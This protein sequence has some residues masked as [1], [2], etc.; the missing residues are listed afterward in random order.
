MDTQVLKEGVHTGF[1][2]I[3]CEEGQ[4]H[5]NY[6]SSYDVRARVKPSWINDWFEEFAQYCLDVGFIV[7]KG[8]YSTM[9]TSSSYSF[10]PACH[11]TVKT[12]HSSI[13]LSF[14]AA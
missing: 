4:K 8:F 2:F 11:T 6:P 10:T 12:G 9:T 7:T 3:G 13:R 14:K 1:D 5:F